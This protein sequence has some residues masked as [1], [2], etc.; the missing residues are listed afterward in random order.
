LDVPLDD[1]GKN[2]FLEYRVKPMAGHT[3]YEESNGLK[4]ILYAY[5][6]FEVQYYEDLKKHNN[7]FE[8]EKDREVLEKG[9]ILFCL[10]G[11]EDPIRDSIT[12]EF[13]KFGFDINEINE[14]F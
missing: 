9:L 1:S 11:L 2:A 12:T 6:D 3:L 10:F 5:R 14:E 8:T 7:N 13:S 4:T